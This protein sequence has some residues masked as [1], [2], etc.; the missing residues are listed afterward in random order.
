M[1]FYLDF[2]VQKPH[3]VWANSKD[4]IDFGEFSEV[5]TPVTQGARLAKCSGRL[6]TL[7]EAKTGPPEFKGE[8]PVM[9]V[10]SDTAKN[11]IATV[12][13]QQMARPRS[14]RTL[15]DDY[16][17]YKVTAAARNARATPRI[18]ELSAPIPRKVRAKKT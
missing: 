18:S 10:V 15:N 9:W 5:L 4:T 12:R 7:A 16:D 8:R 17:P 3:K 13:L 11:A 14:G 1:A 6:E 2:A